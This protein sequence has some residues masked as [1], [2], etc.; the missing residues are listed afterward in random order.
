MPRGTRQ[1]I[2]VTAL[3]MMRPKSAAAPT[4]NQAGIITV[5]FRR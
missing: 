1:A 3:P 5:R 2:A 4:D